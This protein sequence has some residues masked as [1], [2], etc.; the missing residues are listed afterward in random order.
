MA[1]QVIASI[2]ER[3]ISKFS[4]H[5]NTI[6]A[7]LPCSRKSFDAARLAKEK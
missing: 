1:S 4:S 6:Y 3:N 2:S 7:M 5:V